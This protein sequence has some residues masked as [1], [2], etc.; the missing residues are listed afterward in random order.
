M[1]EGAYVESSSSTLSSILIEAE[2]LPACCFISADVTQPTTTVGSNC[3]AGF[4]CRNGHCP[5][6]QLTCV[7][8]KGWS[9]TFCGTPCSLDCGEKGICSVIGGQSVCVCEWGYTGQRCGEKLTST[10]GSGW[11]IYTL[12]TNPVHNY[13]TKSLLPVVLST[14]TRLKRDTGETS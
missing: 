2:H 9:G 3:A 6:G 11:Y 14:G 13:L 1:G 5:A 10:P 12:Y 7:C 4:P 8:D